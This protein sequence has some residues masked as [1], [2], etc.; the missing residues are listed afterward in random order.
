MPICVLRPRVAWHG[1]KARITLYSYSDN[2]L[3]LHG[4]LCSQNK[5]LALHKTHQNKLQTN[6]N[7]CWKLTALAGQMESSSE[8][9]TLRNRTAKISSFTY[10]IQLASLRAVAVGVHGKSDTG[11]VLQ[12]RARWRES[13]LSPH[14]A[15]ALPHSLARHN[16]EIQASLIMDYRVRD[17]TQGALSQSAVPC[18]GTRRHSVRTHFT[19]PVHVYGCRQ[20]CSV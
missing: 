20:R 3:A 17:I 13:T 15:D 19:V 16:A 4:T 8:S 5:G 2:L 6:F 18:A 7:I 11:G 9:D 14:S 10:S 1:N 12:Y